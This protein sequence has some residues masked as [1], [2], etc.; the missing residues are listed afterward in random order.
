MATEQDFTDHSKVLVL[1]E[2][3]QDSEEEQREL[4]EQQKIFI[5]ETD[6]QWDERTTQ[7][8]DD[9]GRY[10]GTFDQ[11]SPI[12]DQISGEMDASEFA[13]DVS[14][15]GG[16]ATEGTADTYAGLIRNIENISNA[17]QIYSA[18]GQSTVMAGYDGFEI[19]Q[20]HLD[21]NTFDQDLIFKPV[22]DFYK[23]VWFDLAAIKQDKSDA[24][25]GVKL[26]AMPAADYDAQ[27]PEGKGISIGDNVTIR[28]A[29]NKYESVIVGKLYYKKPIDIELVKMSNNTIYVKDE[30][31]TKIQ[32][33]L[34][35]Q[36]ITIIDERTRKSWRTWSRLLDGGDWL[37]EEQ[38]TVFSYIPL[39]PAYGNYTILDTKNIYFGKTLKL[40]DS[41]RG[42]NF[43]ISAEVEDV[44]GSPLNDIWMTKKQAAGEDYSNMAVDNIP[45]RFWNPDPDNPQPPFRMGTGKTGNPGLQT[46]SMS[47]QG[48]LQK[49]GNMDDPSMGQN[50]GLQSGAAVNALVSQSNNGNV[51]WFKSMEIAICHAYRVCV[52]AIPRVYDAT[53][54]QRILGEDGTDKMVTLNDVIVD[55]QTG[56]SVEVNN[57]SKGVYDVTCS[58]GA[59]FK[60][61]QEKTT[62]A[63]IDYASIDPAVMEVGRDI[64]LKNQTSPGMDL[65]A[66]RFRPQMIQN[67]LIPEDQWTEEETQQIAQAQQEAEQQPPPPDPAMVLAQAEQGKAEAELQNAA[68]K[69]QEVEATTQIKIAEIQLKDKQLGL[70]TQKFLKGQDDKFNVDAANI[71]LNQQKQELA[72][73]TQ[74][75]NEVIAIAKQQQQEVNDAINNLKTIQEASNPL[76]I[77]G[78]GLVDN[79]KTQS[80][81][82]TEE[83][84]GE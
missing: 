16:D 80:D 64:L 34:A 76:T 24:K 32:D 73:R 38:E 11:V 39:I 9:S 43:A 84:K 19:V 18:V 61:Q 14:P 2:E 7:L 78:P 54:Q 26:K 48:L 56:E 68:N 29:D 27:F 22:S 6:G 50:P 37:N 41:Q 74:E 47:F 3:V 46:A 83:Q 77:T 66:Q 79:L 36:N 31:F 82:V 69:Q 52:D 55:Q 12:L 72:E 63:I 8:L 42:I 49:T 4:V 81:I 60:N 67:G 20:E 53:R 30:K 1:I 44:A 15:A 70:D 71:Q 75:F 17:S 51:K 35:Q 40:M 25:W 5:L 57:L 33:E 13:I 45:V 65:L 62:Q 58:M 10:R 23:S 28:E 21:A 59:A